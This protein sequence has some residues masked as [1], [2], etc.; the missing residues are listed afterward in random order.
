[1]P[2]QLPPLDP[3]VDVPSSSGAG[4]SNDPSTFDFLGA[5][6][7]GDPLKALA[8]VL[9]VGL[10]EDIG[11]TTHFKFAK[12]ICRLIIL[13]S[14]GYFSFL[15][16]FQESLRSVAAWSNFLEHTCANPD[17]ETILRP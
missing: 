3:N 14:F 1:M 4:P 6:L 15:F 8:S 12:D 9:P 13:L 17:I 2:C 7:L 11:R 16:A 5:H 10:F